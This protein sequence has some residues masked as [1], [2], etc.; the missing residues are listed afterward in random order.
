MLRTYVGIDITTTFPYLLQL[1]CSTPQSPQK[2][3]TKSV[4]RCVSSIS[5][6]F[7]PR[8]FPKHMSTVVLC[9]VLLTCGLDCSRSPATVF[10]CRPTPLPTRFSTVHHWPPESYPNSRPVCSGGQK[11]SKK[12]DRPSDRTLAQRHR[13][14]ATQRLCPKATEAQ[15]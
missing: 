1:L 4:T 8:D 9:R 13:C 6:N 3:N 14:T 7:Q 12:A 2:Q 15:R 10:N 11:A 5:L